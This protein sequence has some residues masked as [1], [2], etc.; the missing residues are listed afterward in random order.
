MAPAVRS[1]A[2]SD[3]S[4]ACM[5]TASFRATATAARLKP[6]FYLSFRPQTRKL[7]SACVRVRI[8]VA[9]S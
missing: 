8:T 6:I 4:I 7:L 1:K 9:A 5:M 2:D 3:L